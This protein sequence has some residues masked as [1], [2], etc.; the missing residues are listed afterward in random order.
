VRGRGCCH[1]V[2]RKTQMG[3][4]YEMAW[5]SIHDRAP[6]LS[7]NKGAAV[8]GRPKNYEE[9]T[10]VMERGTTGSWLGQTS[11]MSFTASSLLVFSR[12]SPATGSHRRCGSGWREW[13]SICAI[14]FDCLSR[15]GLRDRNTFCR[16]HG[17]SLGMSVGSWSSSA[18][19]CVSIHV[20]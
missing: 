15:H 16:N 13:R 10:V 18:G 20:T 7:N 11:F 2:W 5:K 3:R 17:T 1:E 9:L 4:F 6:S 14:G 19:M 8:S 12:R